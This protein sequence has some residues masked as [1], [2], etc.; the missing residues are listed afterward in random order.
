VPGRATSAALLLAGAA[1]FALL[2][3]PSAPAAWAGALLAG[4]AGWGWTG[5]LGLAVVQSHPD[6]PGASTALVQAGGCV[7]GIAGPLLMGALTERFGYGTGW[8]VMAGFAAAAGVVAA[9]NGGIWRWVSHT[10]RP[11]EVDPRT[12]RDLT[13]ERTG[14]TYSGT[15]SQ[16]RRSVGG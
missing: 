14:V 10:A 8:Q 3:V 5:V 13:S 16:G 9:V 1:G 12:D 4:G 2:V 6:A 11:S 7:G 15:R